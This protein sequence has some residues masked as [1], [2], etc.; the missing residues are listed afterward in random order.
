VGMQW[1]IFLPQAV[2]EAMSGFA[3]A[4]SGL[5][6]LLYAQ[7][8]VS[9]SNTADTGA[10]RRKLD[11]AYWALVSSIRKTL[12]IEPLSSDTIRILYRSAKRSGEP[13]SENFKQKH[14]LAE[15]EK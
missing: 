13:F 6:S 10:A 4:A 9:K 15:S 8:M 2:N 11:E 14:N 5:V 1:L 7:Q 12:A 3:Q